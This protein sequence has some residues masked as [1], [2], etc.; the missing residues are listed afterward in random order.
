[1]T[2]MDSETESID[3]VSTSCSILRALEKYGP[4]GVTELATELDIAK[5]TIHRH[6]VSLQT[7]H[8]VVKSGDKYQLSL[9][10]LA[11]SEQVIAQLGIFEVIVDTVDELAEATGEVAQ[12][13]VEQQEQLIYIYKAEGE[14][15]IRVVSDVGYQGNFHCT[16]L[17]KAILAQLPEQ[18][19]DNVFKR[20]GLEQKTKNTITSKERLNKELAEIKREGYATDD[21]EFMQGLKCVAAPVSMDELVGAISISAPARRINDKETR[22]DLIAEVLDAA[23][24]IEVNSMVS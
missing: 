16:G 21:Q 1:M 9:L 2:S 11:M 7:E 3:A 15:A 4:M 18:K 23:N 8:F 17:G 10:F 6:I 20:D 5:S 22:E 12:F 24:V 19:V 14:Q 13:A